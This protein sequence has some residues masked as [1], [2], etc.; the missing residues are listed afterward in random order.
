M[1][2]F[3]SFFFFEVLGI[4]F[5]TFA[6]G[7]TPASF[8][9]SFVFS[10]FEIGRHTS[11]LP[12]LGWSLPSSFLAV[13]GWVGGLSQQVCPL[14]PASLSAFSR[15]LTSCRE[16]Y[17]GKDL[18]AR[19][20]QTFP[21]SGA[22]GGGCRMETAT[23]VMMSPGTLPSQGCGPAVRKG[24]SGSGLGAAAAH[25]TIFIFPLAVFVSHHRGLLS[26]NTGQANILDLSALLLCLLGTG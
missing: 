12:G 1:F 24:C 4:G 9:Y 10:L 14:C 23:G 6:L 18:S 2:A 8:I 21:D 11:Q 19:H 20:W 3:S 26:L 17:P 5:S 22:E 16:Q 15:R 25:V 7:C 13:G